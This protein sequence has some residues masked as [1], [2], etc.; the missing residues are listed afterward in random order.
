[1]CPMP[2]KDQEFL[3]RSRVDDVEWLPT[4]EVVYGVH[5]LGLVLFAERSEIEHFARQCW[6]FNEC[7]TW[8]DVRAYLPPDEAKDLEERSFFGGEDESPSPLD[9]DAFVP[10]D[11][12]GWEDSNYPV[13][14]ASTMFDW[15]PLDIAIEYGT[16]ARQYDDR[17]LRIEPKDADVVA[18]RLGAL[19]VRCVRDDALMGNMWFHRQI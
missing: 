15:F 7:A 18:E 17:W 1:M 2:E 16:V 10:E 6:V 5:D 9:G 3:R 14:P 4:E 19:G 12:N 11:V 13:F 8:G